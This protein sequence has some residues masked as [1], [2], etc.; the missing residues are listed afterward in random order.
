MFV[1]PFQTLRSTSRAAWSAGAAALLAAVLGP[2]A[3]AGP[4]CDADRDLCRDACR[5]PARYACRVTVESEPIEK[6]CYLIE[7][8]A[9]CVPPIATSPFDCVRDLFCGKKSHG[10]G[11]GADGCTTAG[12]DGCGPHACGARKAGWLANL[13]N[14]G[15][16]CG[17]GIRCVNTL[18]VHEYECGE[19]C[20]CKWSAVP[21]GACR[22]ACGRAAGPAPAYAA[23]A[24]HGAADGSVPPAP[25]PTPAP[26]TVSF[27]LPTL[28]AA[29]DAD[30]DE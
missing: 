12:C 5:R 10:R 16:G 26:P 27:D 8:E 19:R 18:D 7:S 9:V 21:V 17:G 14:H 20:V 6:E 30:A 2:A 15:R 3:L 13:C 22:D 11:C 25:A 1:R 24:P 23:P 4:P 28:E 29:A